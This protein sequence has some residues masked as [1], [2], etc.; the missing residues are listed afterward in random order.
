MASPFQRGK[1][2]LE[3]GILCVHYFIKRAPGDDFTSKLLIY[4]TLVRLSYILTKVNVFDLFNLFLVTIAKAVCL[5]YIILV[6]MTAIF[7]I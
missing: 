4:P 3:Q 5:L 2:H 7:P 6:I 1:T